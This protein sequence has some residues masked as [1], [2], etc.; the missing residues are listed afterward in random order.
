MKTVRL[1]LPAT[2]AN[3]G[4]G[5]DTLALAL[6]LFL[7]IEAEAAA[8]FSIECSG[9]NPE[10]CG[11]LNNHLLLETY[12]SVLAA[13]HR[14]AVPLALRM[15]N[16][17]PLG[18][19]LGS[20]AAVRLAAV[21]LAAHFGSLA[22]SSSRIVEVAAALEGHPDNV[23]ACWYGGFAVAGSPSGRLASVSISPPAEWRAI[24]VLPDRPVA[25]EHSRS[26]LPEHYSRAD[27]VSNLQNVALLTAAFALRRP[28]LLPLATQ[29]TFHQPYRLQLCPLLPL[30][31]PLAGAGGVLSVTLS[32][33][34][35]A[36]LVLWTGAES[37]TH[38]KQLIL[39]RTTQLALVELIE[40][41][42][43]GEG[44]S[45]DLIG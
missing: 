24:L 1:Q 41:R 38:V 36:V 4:P 44:A 34:G 3:L 21:A 43:W 31:L 19:G 30:L 40:V 25:T 29:D 27:A 8:T 20:S 23:A 39:E 33:A 11:D 2:S 35:P 17:I 22:W 18:M 14:T 28:E 15:K 12:R 26:V 6:E 10:I 37:P 16:G 32:G 42:L 13:E 5:F 7:E 45:L 9:R